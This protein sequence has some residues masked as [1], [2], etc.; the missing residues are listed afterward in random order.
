[1]LALAEPYHHPAQCAP[2]TAII[3]LIGLGPALAGAYFMP[4]I[5]GNA[6]SV[7]WMDHLGGCFADFTSF[8]IGLVSGQKHN[9]RGTIWSLPVLL[10]YCGI[11]ITP[12]FRYAY[13]GYNALLMSLIE[14]RYILAR[15]RG[16]STQ[17]PDLF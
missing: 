14:E 8:L 10:I 11:F 5:V 1:M 17:T 4:V 12:M 13:L 3:Y 15:E 2:T 9:L 6:P 7:Y 16:D